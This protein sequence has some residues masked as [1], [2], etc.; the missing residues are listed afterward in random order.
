MVRQSIPDSSKGDDYMATVIAARKQYDPKLPDLP[1]FLK[2]RNHD[3]YLKS[4]GFKILVTCQ[5]NN[6]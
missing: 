1:I 3:F 5:L 2:A 4:P 6:I